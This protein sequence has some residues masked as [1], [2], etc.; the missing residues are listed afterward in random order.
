MAGVGFYARVID[1]EVELLDNA[2]AAATRHQGCAVVEVWQNCRVHN[3]ANHDDLI[4][5][6]LG[7]RHRLD[8]RPGRPMAYDSDPERGILWIEDQLT[9]QSM[10]GTDPGKFL[11]HDPINTPVNLGVALVEMGLGNPGEPTCF[12]IFLDRT[13]P[14]RI[15]KLAM[16]GGVNALGSGKSDAWILPEYSEISENQ[17]DEPIPDEPNHPESGQ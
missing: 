16:S 9:T 1:V 17:S 2:L 11:V 3:D 10:N 13:T 15:S 5:R 6:Q 12:G 7:K 4:D 8:L 14:P